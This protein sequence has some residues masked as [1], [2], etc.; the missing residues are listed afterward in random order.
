MESSVRGLM[1]DRP[2]LITDLLRFAHRNHGQQEVVSVLADGT[3]HRSNYSHIY[4]RA[5]R[6]AGALQSLGATMGDRIATI[7]WNDYRHLEI[8]YAVSGIGA[9]CHTINPRLFAE[10]LRYI[11]NHAE[12]RWIA[13]DPTFLP[14]VEPLAAELPSV[15]GYILL[16]D[17]E[18][19]P[20]STLPGVLC[21]ED[22][23]DRQAEHRD[24]EDFAWPTFDEN[25]ASSLCYTS[26]TTGHPKG[27]LYSHRS[28]VLHSYAMALPDSTA[29]SMR[30][31]VLP[32]V[33][34][35]HVNAWGM[36]YACPMVGA[37]LVFPGPKMADGETLQ[38]LIEEEGVTLALGVPTIW[39][40]LLQYLESSGKGLGRLERTVV[41]GA[42]CP[43]AIMRAFLEG[44]G[45]RTLHGWGMT[46]M[47][48][49]GTVN[50]PRPEWLDLTV[51]EQLEKAESQ[52]HGVFGVEMRI[53]G[54]AGKELP[55]DGEAFGDLQVRGPWICGEYFRLDEASE[56]HGEEGWFSTGDV[57]SIDPHGYMRIVD[58]TKDVIKT[59]GEWV[60]SIELENIAVGHPAV[61]EA[62]VIAAH[63][64][65]WSERPLLI[66]VLNPGTELS[67]DEMLAFFEGKVATWW[68]PDDVVVV[69]E[70]PHTATGKIQKTKLREQFQNHLLE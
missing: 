8:Y 14:L 44:Y 55:W 42:A 39:L 3:R 61:A 29:L 59:G 10:Q 53:V 64:A 20:E 6:L 68:V 7:A 36:P 31:A 17:R 38:R 45:V 35:F 66:L 5:G 37:K 11:I 54:D 15:E 4:H 47:S 67:R 19:M 26:G 25:T 9:V 51:E 16:C 63:H 21:Y 48:P 57:A 58:R 24:G 2:L 12:D 60:S 49:I 50:T 23:L 13:L 27:V 46:E 22:L 28:T 32:V 69:E 30:D 41:G 33:P 70:I 34:M 43:P 62:A 1:M 65:R 40:A 56:T 52:G 18:S